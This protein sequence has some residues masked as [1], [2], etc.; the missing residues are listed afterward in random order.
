[1]KYNSNMEFTKIIIIIIIILMTKLDINHHS[2]RAGS[3]ALP[4]ETLSVRVILLFVKPRKYP[5]YL[6]L[7]L[8]I[9]S[10]HY[11]L[12]QS[13]N[14]GD[15]RR[16]SGS[17]DGSRDCEPLSRKGS[18]TGAFSEHSGEQVSQKGSQV[19]WPVPPF[20]WCLYLLWWTCYWPQESGTLSLS[21]SYYLWL[22]I[23]IRSL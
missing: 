1:M 15:R 22:T 3:L 9:Y 17:G 14:I 18:N 13:T 10:Y 5:H 2:R 7:F 20:S 6:I 19:C 21:L 16:T 8:V 12:L 23:S 11:S 4:E